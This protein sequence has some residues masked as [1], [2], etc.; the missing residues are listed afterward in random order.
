MDFVDRLRSA[1]AVRVDS[2]ANTLTGVGNAL[3]KTNFQF[4]IDQNSYLSLADVEN[5]YNFDGIAARVVDAVPKHALRQGFTVSTG[6]ADVETAIHEALD[7][8]RVVEVTRNTW[9]WA[10]CFGGAAI[11]LGADDGRPPEE[12]LDEANLRSIR[13]I[14]DVDRRDIYPMT[15]VR[16]P[17]SLEF[18]HPE[19]YRVT[20]MGGTVTESFTVHASRVIRFD[21]VTP[22]RRRRLALQGWG[23]SVLQRVF[24]ELQA[25]RGAFASAGVLLQESSQ[26]VI[27]MKDLM[28]MMASDTDDTMK[29]RLELM[30]QGRSVAR[31]LLLDADGESFERV[32]V[33][34]LTGVADIMDRMVRM[35]AAVTDIPVTILMGQAPAGLNATGDSDIRSWYDAVQ[36]ERTQMLL[37]H[38]R[39]L[40]R[41]LLVSRDGP[42]GG[43]L[44][45]GWKI[46][47]PS[48]WQMTPAETADLRQRTSATDVAYI[49]AGVLTP[50]EVATSRFR[51]EGWSDDTSI[52]LE[53]REA[54]MAA[55]AAAAASPSDPSAETETE[56]AIDA[57]QAPAR[58]DHE[59]A[60]AII[61]K[62][63]GREIPRDAGVALLAS[64]L[65]MTPEA[66]EASMG[67]AGRT[68]FTRP[69][70]NGPDLASEHAKL[71][72]SHRA[73]K[74]MLRRVLAKN[75]AGELV[76]GSPVGAGGTGGVTDAEVDALAKEMEGGAEGREDFDP[77]QK[78]AGNGQF[79][80][81]G[82]PAKSKL[83]KD[84]GGQHEQPTSGSD[85]HEGSFLHRMGEHHRPLLDAM[86]GKGRIED[87][88]PEKRSIAERQYQRVADNPK[89]KWPKAV[90]A[91][92][93]HRA[94]FV[95]GETNEPPGK[96]PD[97]MRRYNLPK[98]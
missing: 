74:S 97:F 96:L 81:G 19:T 91:F 23:E 75:K 73:V 36:S 22:T 79:G 49:T 82:G 6:E 63:A 70:P 7:R 3:G 26:G 1:L 39:R 9:T 29:R 45:A 84:E 54:A 18:T 57:A 68:F 80:A 61:S 5:L 42:T 86:D 78:R 94:K 59:A 33:G 44:P 34:A 30:D 12:P 89:G 77:D 93:L 4:G 43:K 28:G 67:E 37:P 20:R 65:G 13:W 53:A 50:E 2:W 51:R 72:A 66:A 10:R 47:L 24:A 95:R 21:G 71:V 52:D 98:E 35:V 27:K 58:I 87:I 38:M 25:A 11:L 62:V 90:R 56:D 17:D 14:N 41:L 69:D 32:E 46:I 76:V 15:W 85:D 64:S 8:L 55:D 48:L 83:P 16:D 31:A 60:S 40:V 92:N 88:P